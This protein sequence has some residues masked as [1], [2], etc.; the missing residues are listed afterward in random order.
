ML[1]CALPKKMQKKSK[2]KKFPLG[3]FSGKLLKFRFLFF[4]SNAQKYAETCSFFLRKNIKNFSLRG[5]FWDLQNFGK[6]SNFDF[7][8]WQRKVGKMLK[9]NLPMI[10]CKKSN[11]KKNPLGEFSGTKK[12][13]K[14][15][16]FIFWHILKVKNMLRCTLP[17]EFLQ[18]KSNLKNFALR[19]IFWDLENF[20]K[21]F[22]I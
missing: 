16:M 2:I 7:C 1:K 20:W 18:K 15:S 12:F 5:L 13:S 8:F 10:F 4:A 22:K 9:F 3:D 14:T 21:I 17:K 19:G 6:F 11:L